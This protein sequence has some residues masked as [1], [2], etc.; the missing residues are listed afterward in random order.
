MLPSGEAASTSLPGVNLLLLVA[1]DHSE[2]VTG[3]GS[4]PPLKV[5]PDTSLVPRPFFPIVERE[6]KRPGIHCM[7][8]SA[9]ALNC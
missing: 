6:E 1:R 8:G 5:A 4:L 7:G 2:G 3:P 9:R